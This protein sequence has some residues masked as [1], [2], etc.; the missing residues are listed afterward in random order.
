[1]SLSETVFRQQLEA[2][3][4]LRN[5]YVDL[6]GTEMLWR[7]Q[8]SNAARRDVYGDVTHGTIPSELD[9]LRVVLLDVTTFKLVDVWRAGANATAQAPDG[10]ERIKGAVKIGSAVQKGDLLYLRVN[11]P[12]QVGDSAEFTDYPFRVVDIREPTHRVMPAKTIEMVP[13]Y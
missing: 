6:H 12:D 7:R 5:R 8:T 1:M 2:A 10:A 9:V 4:L 11:T 3:I 13:Y